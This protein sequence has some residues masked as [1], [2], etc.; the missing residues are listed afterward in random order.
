MQTNVNV[1]FVVLESAK[2]G[3]LRYEINAREEALDRKSERD[4]GLCGRS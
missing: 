2:L 1:L 4:S 3:T